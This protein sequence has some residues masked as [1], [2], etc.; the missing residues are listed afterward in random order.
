ME[1]RRI[2]GF[3]SEQPIKEAEREREKLVPSR[4]EVS[5]PLCREGILTG[6]PEEEWMEGRPT[7]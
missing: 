5:I 1:L 6:Y 7:R 2:S 4:M 3:F